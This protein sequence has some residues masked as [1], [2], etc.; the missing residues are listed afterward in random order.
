[1][2]S[3]QNA[4]QNVVVVTFVEGTH[5]YIYSGFIWYSLRLLIIEHNCYFIN[6]AGKLAC[7]SPK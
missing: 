7:Y 3:L 5:L 6:F 1:L 2:E 4:L